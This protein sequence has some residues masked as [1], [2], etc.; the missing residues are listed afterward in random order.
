M[1]R[2]GVWETEAHSNANFG[3]LAIVPGFDAQAAMLVTDHHVGS[4][5]RPGA[6]VG[7]SLGPVDDGQ[8]VVV[9]RRDDL[10]R[11]ELTLRLLTIE[12]DTVRLSFLG[13]VPPQAAQLVWPRAVTNNLV[14]GLP[15]PLDGG[16][17]RILGRVTITSRI[18][19]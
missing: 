12:K 14:A 10:H 6:M 13:D 7:I 5:A 1:L 17:L 15:I 8:L 4:R 2:A 19:G 16:E 18:E 9:E 11:R 3:V